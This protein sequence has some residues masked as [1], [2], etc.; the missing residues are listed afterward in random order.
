MKQQVWLEFHGVTVVS[1]VPRD[2]MS[3]VPSWDKNRLQEYLSKLTLVLSENTKL[4]DLV[5]I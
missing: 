1:I 2:T 5:I 4:L 3:Q